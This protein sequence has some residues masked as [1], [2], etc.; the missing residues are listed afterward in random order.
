MCHSPHSELND[1]TMQQQ[2]PHSALHTGRSCTRHEV[3]LYRGESYDRGAHKGGKHQQGPSGRES[4]LFTEAPSTSRAGTG[5]WQTLNKHSKGLPLPPPPCSWSQ[6]Q[7][8]L[9][10]KTFNACRYSRDPLDKLSFTQAVFEHLN[11]LARMGSLRLPPPTVA[12][13]TAT[14]FPPTGPSVQLRARGRP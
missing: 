5:K 4:A 8:N 13:T 9:L 11:L 12:R 1:A 2:R 14:F 7:P 3:K 6:T 10:S